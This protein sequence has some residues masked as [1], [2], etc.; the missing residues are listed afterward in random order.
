MRPQ[1]AVCK[2]LNNTELDGE[3]HE[4]HNLPPPHTLSVLIIIYTALPVTVSL[5]LTSQ[6][7]QLVTR[8][9]SSSQVVGDEGRTVH[10]ML[11]GSWLVLY[12]CWDPLLSPYGVCLTIFQKKTYQL[13]ASPP[14]VAELNTFFSAQHWPPGIPVSSILSG[15]GDC[16]QA[17][18]VAALLTRLWEYLR[19]SWGKSPAWPAPKVL[20]EHDRVPAG[21]NW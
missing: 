21:F 18:L 5:R 16:R 11:H 1:T 9:I 13:L 15:L 6:D 17:R 4:T 14:Q 10:D 3:R 20:V 8:M 2:Y 19:L 12:P 7:D